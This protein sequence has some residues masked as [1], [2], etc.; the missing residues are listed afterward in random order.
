MKM[1][2]QVIGKATWTSYNSIS[3]TYIHVQF[4]LFI[5]PW[6]AHGYILFNKPNH[7][8]DRI[9]F[10]VKLA[11]MHVALI[12]QWKWKKIVAKYTAVKTFH[13]WEIYLKETFVTISVKSQFL[14]GSW[15][16]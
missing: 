6:F 2:G 4:L 16:G 11:L 8:L 10:Y 15:T 9:T 5:P 3:D 13:Q 12:G 14:T 1:N 7:V